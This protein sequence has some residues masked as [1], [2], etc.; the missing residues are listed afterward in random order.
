MTRDEILAAVAAKQNLRGADL[1]GADLSR[2]DLSGAD[3]SG[4][5]LSGDH[6]L[7]RLVSCAWRIRDPYEFFCFETKTGGLLIRAG[8]RTMLA[9]EYTKH[10]FKKYPDTSKARETL[11]ILAHFAAVAAIED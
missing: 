2:A 4:A 8:C 1:S 7:V 6:E 10:V 3:L 11:A 5:Y 9:G